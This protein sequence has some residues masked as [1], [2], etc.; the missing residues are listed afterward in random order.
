MA[1]DECKFPSSWTDN[2]IAGI[3]WLQDFVKKKKKLML[4]QL[5]NTSLFRATAFNTTNIM[6]FFNN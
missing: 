3:D 1:G 2:K 5:E 4:R 6:E